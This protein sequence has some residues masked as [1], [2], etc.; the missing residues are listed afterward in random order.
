MIGEPC[1]RCHCVMT[2][3]DKSIVI[4]G[5]NTENVC[6]GDL[7]KLSLETFEWTKVTSNVPGRTI[8]QNKIFA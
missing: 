4:W 6:H 7:Y 5:G 8:C 3:F 1:P 2:L